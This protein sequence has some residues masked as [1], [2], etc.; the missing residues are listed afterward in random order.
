MRMSTFLSKSRRL[1]Q[2]R[3]IVTPRLTTWKA[4]ELISELAGSVLGYEVVETRE[5]VLMDILGM[6]VKLFVCLAAGVD[7]R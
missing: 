6:F 3:E 4:E 1:S 2:V 7:Y 5:W